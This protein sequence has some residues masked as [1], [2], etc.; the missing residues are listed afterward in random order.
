MRFLASALG[1]AAPRLGLSGLLIFVGF[2]V[3]CFI[4]PLLVR[5]AGHART[6]NFVTGLSII[7]VLAHPLWENLYFWMVLRLFSGIAVAGAATVIESWLNAKLN[8]E[9]R[10]R[11]YSFYRLI[12][13]SGALCAQMLIAS[14]PIA[15]FAS[16]SIIAIF[17]CLSFFPLALTQ[18]VQPALPEHQKWR[19]LFSAFYFTSCGCWRYHCRRNRG[20]GAHDW[21]LIC[22]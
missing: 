8:N 17:L 7:G 2:I 5:R 15:Q 11:Y 18:S 20:S 10:G 3:G 14:L 4:S 6:F 1:L 19:P 13:M 12:D 22:L 21:P 16:Y 9:N